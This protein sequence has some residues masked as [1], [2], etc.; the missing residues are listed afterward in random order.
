MGRTY[1]G[2]MDMEA[3][4]QEKVTP[5]HDIIDEAIVDYGEGYTVFSIV[6][7]VIQL[8]QISVLIPMPARRDF[9]PAVREQVEESGG[10]R[11]RGEG[12]KLPITLIW[13]IALTGCDTETCLRQPNDHHPCTTRR[14]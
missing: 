10:Q 8:A 5:A 11:L 7:L 13:H 2:L 12:C 14:Q 4:S 3:A 6:R 1:E 9:I